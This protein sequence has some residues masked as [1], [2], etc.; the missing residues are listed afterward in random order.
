MEIRKRPVSA[1][2]M[3]DLS[4][5]DTA[6][7]PTFDSDVSKSGTATNSGKDLRRPVSVAFDRKTLTASSVEDD[8]LESV[9]SAST[10]SSQP[11]STSKPIRI[12]LHGKK[13]SSSRSSDPRQGNHLWM[14]GPTVNLRD[15]GGDGPQSVGTVGLRGERLRKLQRISKARDREA[16]MQLEDLLSSC[17]SV[18]GPSGEQYRIA[19]EKL[20][21]EYNVIAMKYL[22]SGANA[23][24]LHLLQGAESVITEAGPSHN[25]DALK[26]LTYNNLGCY[27]RREGRSCI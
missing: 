2:M 20:G 7:Q 9:G 13:V 27:F 11:S 19:A 24:A 16:L 1:T 5:K 26:G 6:K 3:R 23:V 4:R 21:R 14:I 17:S 12:G 10:A 22:Q 25:L 8:P 18:R 15:P